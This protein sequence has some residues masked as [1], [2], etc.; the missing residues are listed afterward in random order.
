MMRRIAV[1]GDSLE[2]GGQVL[3]YAGPVFTIGD[4]GHQVALISGSA[5]CEA[6]KSNGVIGK[7]GGPHRIEFMGETA[8]D[9]D[10][11]LCKCPTPPR[12][13][14]VLSGESWC[15]DMAET[16]GVVASSKTASGGV[17]SVVM[18]V[19]DEQVRPVG[20]GATEGCPYF[21]ETADGRLFMGRIDDGGK[22]PRVYTDAEDHYAVYWGDEALAMQ[23]GA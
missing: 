21:I 19:Y 13:I 5:Y 16:M 22:L 3:P 7:T 11:V 6:C 8:A 1:V 10:V 9:G 20:R 23:D 4:A 17:S 18:D 2:R 12:I 15:D 14:A